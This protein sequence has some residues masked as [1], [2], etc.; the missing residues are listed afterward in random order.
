MQLKDSVLMRFVFPALEWRTEALAYPTG[1][2]QWGSW[3]YSK[4]KSQDS[5]D[6]E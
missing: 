3:K 5:I 6:I 2:R 4:T 1:G